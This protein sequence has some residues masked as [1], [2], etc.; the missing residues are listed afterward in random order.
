MASRDLTSVVRSFA[1]AGAFQDAAPYGSGHINDTYA[2]RCGARG[3]TVRYILQRVNHVVFKEPEKLM[4]NVARV[5]RHLRAKIQAAGGHADREALT[6]VPTTGGQQFHR[7]GEGNLW[8]MYLFID[9]ARTYDVVENPD[10]VYQAAR[11]FGEFQRRLADLPSPRLH[12]TIPDF[13][14]TPKRVAAFREALARD[15]VGRAAGA[16]AEIDFVLQR[17]DRAGRLI[18]MADRGALPERITHNDT[19]FNNVMIDDATGRGLCV[20]DLDTVMPGLVLYDFGDAVR[21]GTNT[22]A[23]DERD[24][25]KVAMD[26]EAFDRL[27]HGYLD[28]AR[29][30]LTEAEIGELAFSGWLITLE[31]GI[32]FLTDHLAGDVYFKVHR[33]GH[34]LDRCRTQFKMVADM[35]QKADRMAAIVDRYRRG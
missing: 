34:N 26:L 9:G 29:D 14:H 23:E 7:D 30:F 28:A 22:G 33:E 35:E 13:H 25:A 32:R 19:K 11:A 1:V 12:E 31:I 10:H 24:L 16:R 17:A 6:L 15:A 21:S 5:T 18:E 2:V 27:A 4:D 3:G 8:R 20:I